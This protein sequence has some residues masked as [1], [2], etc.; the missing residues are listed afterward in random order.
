MGGREWVLGRVATGGGGD[1]QYMTS[2]LCAAGARGKPKPRDLHTHAPRSVP[3]AKQPH[4]SLP[5][6]PLFYLLPSQLAREILHDLKHYEA[7]ARTQQAAH[8]AAMAAA[9]SGGGGS[10]GGAVPLQRDAVPEAAAVVTVAAGAGAGPST[11][12]AMPPPK[13]PAAGEGQRR[14]SMLDG[15]CAAR[16]CVLRGSGCWVLGALRGRAMLMLLRAM[17]PMPDRGTAIHTSAV[18]GAVAK[19]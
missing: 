7:L 13:A 3:F 12:G 15:G 17:P 19:P 4:H 11:A 9:L 2:R 14:R 6:N 10:G 1:V 16:V 8:E 18:F 5:I